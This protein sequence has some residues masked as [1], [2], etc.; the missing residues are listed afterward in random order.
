[1]LGFGVEQGRPQE[2]VGALTLA[3]AVALLAGLVALPPG[4]GEG[5]RVRARARAR[6]RVKGER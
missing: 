3:A 2:L 5:V 4:E 1:M 6:V